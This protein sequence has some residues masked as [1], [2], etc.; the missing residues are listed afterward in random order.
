MPKRR[1]T[2]CDRSQVIHSDNPLCEV[3]VGDEKD[4][5]AIFG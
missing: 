3:C 2:R 4:F 5:D 1:C